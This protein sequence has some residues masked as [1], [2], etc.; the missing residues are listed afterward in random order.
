M[1]QFKRTNTLDYTNLEMDWNVEYDYDGYEGNEWKD[2]LVKKAKDVVDSNKSYFIDGR[3]GTGKTSFVNEIRRNIIKKHIGFSPTNKGAR[4]IG[5]NTIHS[6]YYKFKHNKKMFMSVLN[7]IDYIFID[8]VSMM[9]EMFYQL[10]NMVKRTCP[11]IKFI[12]SGDFGQL[13][14]VNDTWKDG[15]GEYNE[16][17]GM[18]NLCEGNKI[19][20]T[21]CRRADDILFN[22]CKNVNDLNINE[23]PVKE[24]TYLNLAFTHQT[25]KRVNNECMYRYL[26]ETR[27]SFISISKDKHNPKTHDVNLCVGMPVIVHKTN[28]KMDILNSE[29]FIIQSLND[30]KMILKDDTKEI[31]IDTQY[32]HKN[33]YLGFCITIH[34]SQG[35]TFKDKYTIYDWKF[36]KFRDKAKYVALSRATNISNIQIYEHL[37]C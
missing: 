37:S 26:Q 24:K 14:P 33:F 13:P 35:E 27:K 23:Y 25:R 21:K 32:F 8:E 6:I 31:E 29:K 3:A 30:S 7:N 2:K 19:V 17:A 4:L 12:I 36:N 34:A 1:P 5:G 18:W 22:I 20:L 15:K 28:K 11:K 10:F 9:P 16:S